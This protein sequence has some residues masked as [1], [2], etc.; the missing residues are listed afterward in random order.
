MRTSARSF[1]A[2]ALGF[3]FAAA[4]AA[5][6]AVADDTASASGGSHE[7]ITVRGHW[8]IA[9]ADPDGTV[10]ALREFHNALSSSG[11]I[12]LAFLLAGNRTVGGF[13]VRLTPQSVSP[14]APLDC[15]VAEPRFPNI[16]GPAVAKTLTKTVSGNSIILRGSI[17]VPAS[18]DVGLVGTLL[19]FCAGA[20]PGPS[21]VT[22]ASCQSSP[23][24][25]IGIQPFTSA[26]LTSPV[27]VVA[28]Q[29][30]LA[31]VTLSFGSAAPPAAPTSR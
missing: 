22:P 16:A 30:V 17:S 13:A 20:L 4:L 5:G 10:V 1:A 9:V 26:T 18:G 15:V 29:S 14:C 7:G 31:T 28:G 6:P 23:G 21:T 8:V 2:F 27:A 12:L 25:T 19:A 24:I 3:T 11:D